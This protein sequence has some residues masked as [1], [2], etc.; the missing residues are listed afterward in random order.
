MREDATTT[1]SVLL[2]QCGRPLRRVML[3]RLVI[4]G[5]WVSGAEL[6][7]G[8]SSSPLAIEDALADLVI[9]GQAEFRQHVGYRLKGTV[10]TRRA[11]KLMRTE[12]R[13]R[14]VF[15]HQV[16]DEFRVGVAEMLWLGQPGRDELD[17]VMYELVMAMP[18][19]GPKNLAEHVA[20]VDAVLKFA[21]RQQQ[22]G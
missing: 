7:D 2:P 18:A 3:E 15:A 13:R 16:G 8:L 22:A 11:A 5:T 14:G 21:T 6:A 17:L 10:T 1:L 19:P 9:E 4:E 20:Q 12:C